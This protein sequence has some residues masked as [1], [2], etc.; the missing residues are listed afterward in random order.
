MTLKQ[1]SLAEKPFV[2]ESCS[3]RWRSS[4][5]AILVGVV[6][7]LIAPRPAQATGCV[8]HEKPTFGLSVGDSLSLLDGDLA[9]VGQVE[10]LKGAQISP[11]PC[12]SESP[13]ESR[14]S[15]NVSPAISK[16]EITVVAPISE[17]GW[18]S[19]ECSVC[20]AHPMT[21]ERPPRWIGSEIETD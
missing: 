3:I 5:F 17:L 21:L 6:A 13:E 15:S 7:L 18:D 19:P 9:Q 16:I 11:R 12:S 1:L 4:G 20:S 2:S 10:E 14:T 8:A